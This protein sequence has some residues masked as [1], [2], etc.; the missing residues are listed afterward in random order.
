MHNLVLADRNIQI[1]F[2]R[3]WHNVGFWGKMQL[4]TQIIYSIFSNETISEEELEKMKS[5]DM[6]NSILNEFTVHFPKLKTPLIDERD[7]YL[8][9]KI[10]EA[11]G[12]KVV[13]VLGAA[14]VPGIKEEIK[15]EHDLERLSQVPPK[16]K[17]PKIIGWA[18]PIIHYFD[19]CLY[20]LYES[21]CGIASNT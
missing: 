19:Y 7:Q 10:K 11:P 14:H 4:L 13:A 20:F 2:S 3:I 5:Q 1:T 21:I 17:A 18:I 12:K 15:K 9:Q 8:A 6:L 16:S